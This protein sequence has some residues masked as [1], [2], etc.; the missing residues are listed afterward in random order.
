MPQIHAMSD[1]AVI[2]SIYDDPAPLVVM[3]CMASG[4]PIITTDSGGIPEYIGK[5]NCICIKRDNNIVKDLQISLQKLIINKEYRN[6]LGEKAH[7]YAQQF[8]RRKFYEDFINIK[9]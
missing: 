3:E 4:L 8:N 7:N 9:K 2:P 5:N 1:I 6:I